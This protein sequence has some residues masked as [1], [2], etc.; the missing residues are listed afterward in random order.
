MA[1]KLIHMQ[2]HEIFLICSMIFFLFSTLNRN[3][4]DWG[5]NGLLAYASYAVIVILDPKNLKP[6]QTLDKDHSFSVTHLKWSKSWTK[7]VSNLFQS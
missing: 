7:K 5:R 6:I 1:E 2:F 4:F 3:A